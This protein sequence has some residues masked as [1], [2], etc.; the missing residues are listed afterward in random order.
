MKKKR[1]LIFPAG[2]EN[3]LEIYDALRYN[4]NV[5]VF[6]ASGK[7]DFAEY[8]YDAEHYI[9]EQLYFNT[10]GFIDVFNG[11]LKRYVIDVVIPTHDDI[12]LF[13]AEHREEFV[14]KILVSELDTARVCRSKKK[15]YELFEKDDF[16]P[17][18]YEKAQEVGK[19]SYPI[20]YKPDVAAG[21][22]G[23]TKINSVSELEMLPK[24]DLQKGV[25][26]EFLP[27]IEYTVDCFTNRKGELLFVG[28]RTRDRIVNGIAYRSTEI[29]TTREIQSIAEAINSRLSFFGAWYFQ[30]K[31][32]NDRK[33]K[34]RETSCRQ[35]TGM[36]L[37]R[38]KG[39]NFP[40][41]G[42]FE[43]FGVDTSF[44]LL[45]C[46]LQ[47]E[48]RLSSKFRMDLQYDT[49][50]LDFDDTLVVRGRVCLIVIQFLFQCIDDGK[51]IILLTRHQGELSDILAEHRLSPKLFDEIIHITFNEDKPDFIN[52]ERAILVDNSFAERKLINDRLGIPVFDVDMVDML[53][54]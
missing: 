10:P 36:N 2:A 13:L 9:E 15:T 19:S 12:T 35:S 29:E 49:V 6:G 39:I 47:M 34:L 25:L 3:A 40:M 8:Q 11:I 52:A 46:K 7:K 27:G 31:E 42:R 41:L 44:V 45:E 17:R 50:Y 22:V 54:E 38:H 28:S 30:V 21:G 5:E 26:C 51:K 53:L 4:V 14:A 18:V 1:V 16:C 43:L 24:D 33:L 23:V 20:L 32:D 48:R 37:Y